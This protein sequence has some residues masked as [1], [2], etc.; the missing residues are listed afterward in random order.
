MLAEPL[1]AG[2]LTPSCGKRLLD[3]AGATEHG[4]PAQEVDS[5]LKLGL[6]GVRVAQELTFQPDLPRKLA[7]LSRQD[8]SELTQWYAFVDPVLSNLSLLDGIEEQISTL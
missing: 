3:C 5:I 4:D 1:F 8:L 2:R 6:S 7:T